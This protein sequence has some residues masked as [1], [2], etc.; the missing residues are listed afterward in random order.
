LVSVQVAGGVAL[1][2]FLAVVLDEAGAAPEPRGDLAPA[3]G[4]EVG[5]AAQREQGAGEAEA[6]AGAEASA[7]AGALGPGC[8]R[9]PAVP[10]A[11]VAPGRCPGLALE[12]SGFE[13]LGAAAKPAGDLQAAPRGHAWS[14]VD[15][16]DGSGLGHGL[17]LR[18]R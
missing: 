8:S 14:V 16:E 15:G 1:V 12:P 6:V 7:E 11:S 18:F 10:V 4:A 3:A 5:A 13:L 17:S 2:E 9:A